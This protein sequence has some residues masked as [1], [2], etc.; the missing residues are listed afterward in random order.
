M[1]KQDII[2]FW[3]DIEIFDLPDLNK[4]AI[5][6]SSDDELP[7]LHGTRET[8]KHY[9]WRFTLLFGKIDKKF[10][11]EHLNTLLKVDTSNDWEEPIQGFSCFSTLILDEKGRP[12]NDSYIAASYIFGI[13]ALEKNINLSSVSQDLDR[14]REDFFERYNIPEVITQDEPAPKGD[15]IHS[16]HLKREIEY[17]R[18]LTSWWREDIKVFLL[19]EEVPRDSEP[20]PNFMN[21]FYLDDLN[22]LSRIGETNFSSTLI[23]YLQLQ[24]TVSERRD[25]IENKQH[26]F[27]AI[28][29][30]HLTAG[31]WPS[32]I[33]YGLYTAQSGAINTIF[34]NLRNNEGLQ[35]INGPPG[36][37]KTTLLLDVIS[38]IIVERAKVISEIG[39]D[40]IFQKGY[41]KIEKET[42]YS[43]YTYTINPALAKN[44]GIV[45]ASN[46]NAAVENITKEL[47][48]KSKIDE[49]NFPGA[50]YFS[51]CSTKLI[52]EPSWGA[53]AAALGNSKNRNNF[54]KSF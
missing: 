33:E 22:Y 53:L 43:L 29:P 40:N 38:E 12:Q 35:G 16:L 30:A 32:K 31:R 5:L 48:L 23:E 10:I 50:D 20:N 36:T 9:K 44:F 39:C 24:P 11:L 8:K 28:N 47:P 14:V 13:N 15:V 37:G 54:R 18:G 45:V 21:S 6:I 3:R 25:L 42:G 41:K 49:T 4:E 52:D 1:K 51:E 27:D 34:S 26:L 19:A 2:Q 46:N 17:L 7:W